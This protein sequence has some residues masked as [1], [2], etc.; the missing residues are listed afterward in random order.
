MIWLRANKK[1]RRGYLKPDEGPV[2]RA[3][4]ESE[5]LSVGTKIPARASSTRVV[6][7]SAALLVGSLLLGLAP[8]LWASQ[9]PA[10]QV[11]SF[12]DPFGQGL[13]ILH[14][15]WTGRPLHILL[16]TRPETMAVRGRQAYG[17][18]GIFWADQAST[19]LRVDSV[20]GRW[21]EVNARGVDQEGE[22]APVTSEIRTASRVSLSPMPVTM[23]TLER[24][25]SSL[26]S[27]GY[28]TSVRP[29]GPVVPGSKG[30]QAIRD[31]GRSV[32]AFLE[33][34]LGVPEGPLGDYV[35][36]RTSRRFFDLVCPR[37]EVVAAVSHGRVLWVV[38]LPR[39]VA[40]T[41]EG[42]G[43]RYATD[44]GGARVQ[45]PAGLSRSNLT[46]A[47]T[48]L[49]TKPPSLDQLLEARRR[50][51]GGAAVAAVMDWLVAQPPPEQ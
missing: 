3:A 28:Y 24:L 33:T 46:G 1:E 16:V 49:R 45:V 9:Q 2:L 5:G 17:R 29:R 40:L 38:V 18:V 37:G 41:L 48:P 25:Q 47:L 31:S 36:G 7:Q 32:P 34:I 42:N 39:D 35:L 50:L 23:A 43:F 11:D 20:A 14:E 4:L 26:V 30:P 27:S 44:V 10:H 19:Y 8:A 22:L 15:R 13:V 12:Q 21:W 6:I 51:L